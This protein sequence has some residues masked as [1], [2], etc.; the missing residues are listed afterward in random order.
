M[1]DEPEISTAAP[2]IT[3]AAK[4]SRGRPAK[5]TQETPQQRINRLQ[6]ELQ[7]AH[8][9]QKKLEQQRDSVVGRVVVA[10]A[11]AHAEYRKQ[12]VALLREEVT[13]KGDLAVIGELLA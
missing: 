8:E 11:L 12:L 7:Q 5:P 4:K 2:A 3:T 6:A 9:A 10:H 13:S 1:T